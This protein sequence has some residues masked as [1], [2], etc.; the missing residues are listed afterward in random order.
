MT[1]SACKWIVP[2]SVSESTDD[3]VDEP[4]FTVE[5]LKRLALAAGFRL[6][7]GGDSSN[8]ASVEPT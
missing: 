7:D 6:L 4:P 8:V 5:E 2:E 3:P 1:S